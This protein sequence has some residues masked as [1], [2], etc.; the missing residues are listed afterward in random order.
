[1][2]SKQHRFSLLYNW[3]NRYMRVYRDKLR[4]SSKTDVLELGS[5]SSIMTKH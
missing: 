3:V 5:S 2:A 4:L 1:M